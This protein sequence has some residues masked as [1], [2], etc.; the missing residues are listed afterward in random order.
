MSMR[1]LVR[2]G[3]R[4]I[5]AFALAALFTGCTEDASNPVVELEA[6]RNFG[7]TVGSLI[8]HQVKI[9]LPAGTRVDPKLLPSS[10]P[11]TDALD[12]RAIEWSQPDQNRLELRLRYLILQGVKGP[13]SSTIPPLKFSVRRG[14]GLTELQTPEWSFALMPVIPPG[15][16]DEKVELRPMHEIPA[17]LAGAGPWLFVCGL[18]GAGLCA[19]LIALQRG[20]FPALA[21]PPP[22]TAAL[23]ALTRPS[24]VLNATQRYDLALKRVHRAIDE[25]AGATVL[26]VDLPA[27]LERHPGFGV[28]REQFVNFFDVSQRHFF[29]SPDPTPIS[30]AQHRDLLEFCRR[31]ARIERG[32][33]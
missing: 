30:D 27:F 1:F 33:R 28:V 26:A 12:L 2:R 18:L 9:E 14:D 5:G 16:P 15:I 23:R 6:R 21:A 32:L 8:E 17:V 3:L 19:F 20:L 7:Y 31:C 13:E 4:S 11:V 22:F 29:G 24:F 10:G 25:T